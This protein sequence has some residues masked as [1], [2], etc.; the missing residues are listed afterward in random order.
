MKGD[1]LKQFV[2]FISL[3]LLVVSACHDV[4]EGYLKVDHACYG[5]DTLFVRTE[6]DPMYD[7]N[8]QTRLDNEAPWVTTNISGVLGTEPLEYEFVSVK[9]SEGG[10][11]VLFAQD[12]TV[13]GCGKIQIPL[14]PTAPKG[15]YLVSIKVSNG[16]HSAILSDVITIIIK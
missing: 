8:D 4:K 7:Y 10:D 14:V 13:G 2:I 11:A 16:D 15:T 5:S 12:I 6:L 3:I 1:K 9:A